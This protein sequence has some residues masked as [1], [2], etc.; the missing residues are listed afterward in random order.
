MPPELELRRRLV[1][2]RVR[3]AGYQS[4]TRRLG[5]LGSTERWRHARAGLDLPLKVH[6]LDPCLF[7]IQIHAYFIVEKM[8]DEYEK[9]GDTFYIA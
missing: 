2:V 7:I 5:E 6:H 3:S 9:N 4:S 8:E 1:H